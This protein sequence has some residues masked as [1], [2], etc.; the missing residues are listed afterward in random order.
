MPGPPIPFYLTATAFAVYQAEKG[1][2]GL[3]ERGGGCRARKATSVTSAPCRKIRILRGNPV[4]LRKGGFFSCIRLT[5]RVLWS[6]VHYSHRIFFP[7][8]FSLSLLSSFSFRLA[9]SNVHCVT[10]SS[11]PYSVFCR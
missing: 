4:K 9:S 2:T 5:M 1:E 6:Y 7:L 3:E 8:S 11:F 10:C